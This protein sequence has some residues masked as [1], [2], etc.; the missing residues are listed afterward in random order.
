MSEVSEKRSSN[1]I[2]IFTRSTDNRNEIMAKLELITVI[3]VPSNAPAGLA[4]DGRGVW[5]NDYVSGE[6][7]RVEPKSTNVVKMLLCPGVVSGLTFDGFKLWQTRLDEDWLQVINPQTLDFD[8]TI[9]L[10][11]TGRLT[12]LTWDGTQLWIIS[13]KQGKIFALDLPTKRSIKSITIPEATTGVTYREGYLW[14]SYAHEMRYDPKSDSFEWK[15]TEPSYYIAKV[16]PRDGKQVVK[17]QVDFLPVGIVWVEDR[18]W[19]SSAIT[20]TLNIFQFG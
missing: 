10:M 13:Q 18:L 14:I 19:L 2:G 6:L 8:Q 12:D 17:Y 16:D 5:L 1:H 15:V 9:P 11:G 7:F 3:N 4:W 20:G